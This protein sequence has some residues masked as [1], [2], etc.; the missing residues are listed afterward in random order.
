MELNNNDVAPP[1]GA[2]EKNFE[3]ASSKAAKPANGVLPIPPD[4]RSASVSGSSASDDEG[5][6]NSDD[7]D[8]AAARNN[9]T[10][11]NRATSTSK[12]HNAKKRETV[13]AE[14]TYK[15]HSQELEEQSNAGALATIKKN[16]PAKEVRTT[17]CTV[18]CEAH[19][20]RGG[21]SLYD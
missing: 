3:S 17:T 8:V 21:H 16:V 4:N 20:Q 18:Q 19:A 9:N 10:N 12:H 14:C 11:K 15:D 5:N 7:S 1:E 6:S 2:A 13:L